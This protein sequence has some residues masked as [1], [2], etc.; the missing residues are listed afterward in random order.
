MKAVARSAYR[1]TAPAASSW[2]NTSI[3]VAE[4]AGVGRLWTFGQ[5]QRNKNSPILGPPEILQGLPLK[6]FPECASKPSSSGRDPCLA[7]F[8]SIF[9]LIK[10]K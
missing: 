7:S 9:S 6:R 1:I 4:Y 5:P 8:A 2:S 3:V 10:R